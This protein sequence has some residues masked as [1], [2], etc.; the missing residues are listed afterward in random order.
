MLKRLGELGMRLA[1]R[2]AEEADQ[3]AAQRAA[4][5]AAQPQAPET[6]AKPARP[7]TDARLVFNRLA[8]S[9]RDTVALEATLAAGKIPASPRERQVA[10]PPA[11][12]RPATKDYRRAPICEYLHD[13][14]EDSTLP[15]PTRAALHDQVEPLID[16]HLENDPAQEHVGGKIAVDICKALGIP[17]K[18]SRM[19][20]ELLVRPGQTVVQAH[21]ERQAQKSTGPDPP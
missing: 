18:T 16:E 1:E 17:F 3:E 7:A 10:E 9:V 2:A 8:R 19:Q 4:Q 21:R 5:K 20:D 6:P 11:T 12:G 14:I 13:A 15:K